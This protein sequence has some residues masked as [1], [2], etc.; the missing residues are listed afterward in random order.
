MEDW[1]KIVDEL[2]W[3]FEFDE[4]NMILGTPE[5]RA[6]HRAAKEFLGEYYFDIW[7]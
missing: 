7:C 1:I 4:N 6:R 5:I 3:L 2:I